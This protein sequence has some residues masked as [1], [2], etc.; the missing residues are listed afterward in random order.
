MIGCGPVGL[1]V[2]AGLKARGYGPVVAADFSP[3]RRAAAEAMGADVVIDPAVD[4]PARPLGRLRRA[5]R[6]ARPRTW[7]G[8]MGKTFGRPVVFECVGAPGVLQSADRGGPG[9][10]PDRRRRRLHGDRPDRALASPSPK[11]IEL[12]LRARLRARRVRRRRLRRHR[13]GRDQRGAV[14]HR[15]RSASRAW[16]GAFTDLGD[17]EAH[18]KIL[19]EPG[20]A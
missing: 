1:A 13:R 7:R 18:V 4:G 6:P 3:R 14:D 10:G 17:P 16:P 12:H 9:R 8:M 15:A 20:R 11:E 2:I 5:D 19:V